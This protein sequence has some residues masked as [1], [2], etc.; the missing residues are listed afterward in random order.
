MARVKTEDIE[1]TEASPLSEELDFI[2]FNS[3]GSG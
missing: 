2:A 3:S 1:A